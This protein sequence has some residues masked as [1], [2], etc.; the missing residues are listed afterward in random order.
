MSLAL[1]L[2]A[3]LAIRCPSVSEAFGPASKAPQ[4]LHLGLPLGRGDGRF[5]RATRRYLS[6]RLGRGDG[7]Y[8]RATRR[9][10]YYDDFPPDYIRDETTTNG[11]FGRALD[12]DDAVAKGDLD[13]PSPSSSVRISFPRLHAALS[14]PPVSYPPSVSDGIVQKVAL[15]GFVDDNDIFQFAKAFAAPSGDGGRREGGENREEVLSRTLMEDFGWRALD[16][17]RARVGMARLVQEDMGDIRRQEEPEGGAL[18]SEPG[19]A[20][21][22]PRVQTRPQ[23]SIA[24]SEESNTK[25]NVKGVSVEGEIDLIEEEKPALWKSVLVN[26]RAKTRRTRKDPKSGAGGDEGDTRDHQNGADKDVYHY[27]LR[28]DAQDDGVDR[29]AY[30]A[31]YAELDDYWSYMTVPQASIFSETPIREQTASTYLTHARQF[32]GWMVD[33]R[34]VL[35]RSDVLEDMCRENAVKEEEPAPSLSL[36]ISSKGTTSDAADTLRLNAWRNVRERLSSGTEASN[37]CL[38]GAMKEGLRENVSLWDIFPTPQVES[39]APVLQ[40]ILWLRSE[41]AVSPNYEANILR[42]LIKLTKFRFARELSQQTTHYNAQKNGAFVASARSSPL[43]DLPIVTELRKL[44]REAGSKGKK[45]PRSSDEGKKWL[46]WSE[47]LDVVRLLK[48]DLGVLMDDYNKRVQMEENLTGTDAG[49]GKPSRASSKSMKVLRKEIATAFQRYLILS[50]FACV[51]DRQRTY[52]ELQLGRNFV[53]IDDGGDG[54]SMW[55]IK[56][57]AEDYKTGSTYGE[58]PPLPL[59]PYLTSDIDDFL[60]RWRPALLRPGGSASSD[61]SLHLFLQPRTG[62]PLTANSVYQIVSRCCYKY[63]RKKTNPHLLRD[64]IVTHV[65]KNADAS[66]KELEALALFMGHSIQMQRDSYDRRTLEQ[67]VSPAVKLMENM[68]SLG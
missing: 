1:L 12:S 20:K 22:S 42:G 14:T 35:S 51:P 33:A 34:G 4:K 43:D 11:A 63:K 49:K 26:D 45:A 28:K 41:R 2:P 38:L 44:H 56:H 19:E 24:S 64:M 48:V 55:I 54:K 46:E 15:A 40:Y 47:Y 3:I 25:A 29:Q 65:R 50:F 60:D 62:N 52:R 57:T 37:S 8:S 66:E 32:L 61:S 53:K 21:P 31:L 23:P 59:T 39:A 18:A 10:V 7:R 68:S 13:P 58:R 5:S 27:G 30:A 17:H 9:Y 36:A 67:K 6:L 16:A